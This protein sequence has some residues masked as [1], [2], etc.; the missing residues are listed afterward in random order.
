MMTGLE[1]ILAAAAAL[2]LIAAVVA[3][4]AAQRAIGM[5]NELN[6]QLAESEARILELG[7]LGTALADQ[8]QAQN[9]RMDRMQVG[10]ERLHTLAG[11]SGVSEAI[12]L[13]RH[14][15]AARELIDSCGLSRGEARLVS[16]LY[17]KDDDKQF[18]DAALGTA[19]TAAH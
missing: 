8:N 14:G 5:L 17:G 2:G 6:E 19:D 16:V 4:R 3:L 18:S 13:T 9:R 7:A 1:G 12:A 11:R 15:A 10:Q